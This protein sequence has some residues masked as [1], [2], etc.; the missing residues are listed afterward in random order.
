ML[1]IFT[2]KIVDFCMQMGEGCELM[3]LFVFAHDNIEAFMG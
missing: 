3:K 2:R 1:S